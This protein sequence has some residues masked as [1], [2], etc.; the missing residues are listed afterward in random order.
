MNDTGTNT[1]EAIS[2]VSH[3]HNAHKK[4]DFNGLRHVEASNAWCV[5]PAGIESYMHILETDP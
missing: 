4:D 3:S 1:I 5:M 2:S